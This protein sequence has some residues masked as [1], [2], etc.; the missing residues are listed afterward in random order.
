MKRASFGSLLV[1][2]RGSLI[3]YVSKYVTVWKI[4]WKNRDNFIQSLKK[5]IKHNKFALENFSNQRQLLFSLRRNNRSSGKRL[6]LLFAISSIQ[7]LHFPNLSKFTLRRK[8]INQTLSS[9][10]T[11][12]FFF[13]IHDEI[14]NVM[15]DITTICILVGIK[16]QHDLIYL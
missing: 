4:I 2:K 13:L 6:I 7:F 10:T 5:F 1:F 15:V 11:V 8:D 3:V 14:N 16:Y 9:L 12:Y